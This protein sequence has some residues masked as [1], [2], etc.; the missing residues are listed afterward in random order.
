MR[1]LLRDA[2][3]HRREHAMILGIHDLPAFLAAGIALNLMPGA[4]TLYIIGRSLAQGRPAGIV[5]ALGIGTGCLC[6]TAAVAF[7]LSALLATSEYA[8]LI[9]KSLGA[10]YL[11]VLGLLMFRKNP[12][13]HP[14]TAPGERKIRLWRIYGQ[15]VLTNLSNPKVALFFLAFLPQFISPHN[16]FGA[17]PF[18]L[19][20]GIF[21]LTGTLWCLVIAGAAA[22]L[23]RQMR[24]SPKVQTFAKRLTGLLF[25]GLGIKLASEHL[26]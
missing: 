7:G 19:L 26:P 9:V 6:H 2:T 23:S 8:F 18:L 5:S 15:G 20:G 22:T 25:L 14:A 10:A 17:L 24:N 16:R 11:V 1:F 4:D 13:F 3:A 12:A 21:V